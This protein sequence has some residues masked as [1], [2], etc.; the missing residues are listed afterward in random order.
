VRIIAI[1]VTHNR[2]DLLARCVTALQSQ[3]RPADKV[4]VI[5]NDSRDGTVEM[6]QQRGIE[7][8][9]QPNV[10]SAGGWHKGIEIAMSEGFDAV[11]LMDDDGFADTAALAA[12]E[13][14]LV[15]GV[16]CASSVVLRENQPT[17]FVFA[18]PVLDEH[19]LPVIFGLPRKLATLA[20]LRRASRGNTYPFAH[21][22][23]GA[24]L[25]VDAARCIGNVDRDFFIF[26]DEVDYFFRLRKAGR[27]VSV[28]DAAHFHPDVGRRP[29]TP[30]KIY[31]YI[32]NTLILNRRYFNAVWLRNCMTIA[33]ALGRTWR[34][35]GTM[36][37][38][39]LLAGS[40]APAFYSAIANGL[41]GK[42]GKDFDA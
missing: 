21:F 7:F 12:L 27:V 25:S 23:N 28:L 15:P 22:F 39:S 9:T 11:W 30:A 40:D 24:L 36:A 41:R 31:Y 42:V 18:F 5:N 3:T 37:V 35:N 29:Y 17:H 26:G 20:D 10:G 14:A 38:L 6:L 34:R 8:V 13:R 16:A 4:L 33:V 2:R 1:V 19:G 32:K